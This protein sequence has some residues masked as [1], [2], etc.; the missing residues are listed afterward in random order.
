MTDD[1]PEPGLAEGETITCQC[2]RYGWVHPDAYTE[3]ST[4]ERDC[5]HCGSQITIPG[6]RKYPGGESMPDE[7]AATMYQ[8]PIIELEDDEDAPTTVAE[9]R[10]SMAQYGL[11]DQSLDTDEK[12]F[13]ALVAVAA[14]G[15]IVLILMGKLNPTMQAVGTGTIIVG[16]TV[17]NLYK[18]NL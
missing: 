15:M 5:P 1:T 13:V 17:F 7:D 12:V 14:L 9:S 3:P 8:P 6:P 10:E 11:P 16:G 2:G 4:I 18:G